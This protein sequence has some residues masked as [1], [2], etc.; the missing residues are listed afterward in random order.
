M[1]YYCKIKGEI[2][3]HET[4]TEE[5]TLIPHVLVATNV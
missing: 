1:Y 3:T 2:D 5:L 4:T